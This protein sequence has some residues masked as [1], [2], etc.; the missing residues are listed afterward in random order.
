MAWSQET[1]WL[2]YNFLNDGKLL[3]ATVPKLKDGR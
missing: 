1:Y 2:G 3:L